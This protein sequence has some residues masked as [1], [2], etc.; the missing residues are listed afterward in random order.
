MTVLSLLSVRVYK[1]WRKVIGWTTESDPRGRSRDLTS[2]FGYLRSILL[3]VGRCVI[4]GGT[5]ILDGKIAA[6]VSE[7]PTPP[8]QAGVRTVVVGPGST[9]TFTRARPPTSID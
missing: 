9:A 7:R 2:T 5:K 8:D 1:W 4:F 6:K 3:V